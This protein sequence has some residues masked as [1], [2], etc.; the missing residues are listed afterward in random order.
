MLPNLR[1]EEYYKGITGALTV[2][3]SLSQGEYNSDQ[4]AKKNQKKD[5]IVTVI[6]V[7]IVIVIVVV[8]ISKGRGNGG[9]GANE[10]TRGSAGFFFESGNL[11]LPG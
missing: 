10:F 2:L 9:A 7:L 1:N 3:K 11:G 4:Y 5:S 8:I 6:I